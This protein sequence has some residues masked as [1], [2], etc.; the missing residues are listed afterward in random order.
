MLADLN[1]LSA[2]G[3][4]RSAHARHWQYA[5]K[6]AAAV[7][8]APHAR[9]HPCVLVLDIEL[10]AA[11]ASDYIGASIWNGVRTQDA[12]FTLPWYSCAC[13]WPT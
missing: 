8:A 4:C 1:V 12:S 10:S 2:D 11:V 13:T 5:R 3:H 6:A 7:A 9:N